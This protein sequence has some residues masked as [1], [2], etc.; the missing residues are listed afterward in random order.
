MY[1][2]VLSLKSRPELR[3][4]TR[5]H[6]FV[7]DRLAGALC[8]LALPVTCAGTSDLVIGAAIAACAVQSENRNRRSEIARKF[9]GNS[10]RVKRTHVLYHGT[11]LY[12]FDLSLIAQCLKT[13]PRQPAYRNQRT[14]IDFVTNLPLELQ[15]LIDAI[16]AAFPTIG[17]L[18]DIPVG[19]VQGLVAT[20]F[21]RGSWNRECG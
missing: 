15:Q 7:L 21:A 3:D 2:A 5:A 20:R 14:H 12:A 9:S 18:I 17:E 16:D 13:P 4:I 19:R 10:L 8:A 11:L 1:A 6:R